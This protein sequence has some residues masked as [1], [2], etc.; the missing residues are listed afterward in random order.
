MVVLEMYQPPLSFFSALNAGKSL[1][2]LANHVIARFVLLTTKAVPRLRLV[3]P[4]SNQ[5]LSAEISDEGYLVRLVQS[6]WS[7]HPVSR[8]AEPEAH[9]LVDAE[10]D[11]CQGTLLSHARF[12]HC[13]GRNLVDHD[14]KIPYSTIRHT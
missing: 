10:T 6:H 9:R 11:F 1:F 13:S 3:I 14:R 4:T 12:K 8:S 2:E 5:Y 7:S